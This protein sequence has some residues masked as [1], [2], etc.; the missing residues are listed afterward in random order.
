MATHD[1][2][3]L[4][5]PEWQPK[6]EAALRDGDAVEVAKRVND[7]EYAIFRRLQD[8]SNSDGMA[9]R[10][11]IENALKQLLIIKE[12]KLGFPSSPDWRKAERRE[13]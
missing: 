4:R 5:Y 10:I 3:R 13:E 8:L 11:A 9:E 2:R 6:Y 7:A 1:N 12:T